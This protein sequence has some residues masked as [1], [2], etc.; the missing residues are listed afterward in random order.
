MIGQYII[1]TNKNI[2]ITKKGVFLFT[3]DR[4]IQGQTYSMV[5]VKGDNI[6]M[7]KIISLTLCFVMI[8]LSIP[9]TAIASTV[10]KKDIMAITEIFDSLFDD[11]KDMHIMKT[12]SITESTEDEHDIEYIE[13]KTEE[14][15]ETPEYRELRLRNIRKIQDTY[16]TKLQKIQKALNTQKMKLKR[17]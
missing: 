11:Q 4:L 13:N 9:I 16:G 7:K 12:G 15:A 14:D 6:M 8:L 5:L 3:E 17:M 10:G 1:D 2:K